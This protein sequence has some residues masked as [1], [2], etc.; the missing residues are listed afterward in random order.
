MPLAAGTRL[1]P[2]EII[3]PLGVGGMGEV[4]RARDTKLKRDVAIKVLP[5][6]VSGDAERL[7]RLQREAK[8]S[9]RSTIPISRISRCRRLRARRARHGT[10]RGTD[11]RRADCQRATADRRG[12]GIARQIAEAL[13][14][15]RAGDRPP[16]PETREHQGHGRRQVKVLDFGLAK[17][18]DPAAGSRQPA[19]GSD[20][21]ADDR[22]AGD[23]AG[24]HDPRDRRLHESRAG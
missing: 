10:G 1:G 17:A 6:A 22:L 24:R 9:P 23:D 12:A 13:G 3:A 19:T 16:R 4:Y 20:E 8:S 11:A 2:Y 7:A 14:G 18:L 21:L 5:E 15:A